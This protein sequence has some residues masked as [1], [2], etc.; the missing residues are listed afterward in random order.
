MINLQSTS[1]FFFFALH[2]RPFRA[3]LSFGTLLND[4]SFSLGLN[5]RT[6]MLQ[7]D[8]S[9][10]N[11]HKMTCHLGLQKKKTLP[12]LEVHA[13]PPKFSGR[14][15]NSKPDQKLLR[16]QKRVCFHDRCIRNTLSRVCDGSG[17]HPITSVCR[18][19][20]LEDAGGTFYGWCDLDD[21]G[22][23]LVAQPKHVGAPI[24][25]MSGGAKS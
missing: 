20:G 24:T 5:D 21:G 22:H 3:Y 14:P 23:Y 4:V 19:D 25:A 16:N 17:G 18:R 7:K 10:S 13:P 12:L 8:M 6:I 2:Y 11:N 1:F 9:L 15:Q